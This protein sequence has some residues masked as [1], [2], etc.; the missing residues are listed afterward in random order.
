MFNQNSG[1]PRA[2]LLR[3]PLILAVLAAGLLV[4]GCG[5]SLGKAYKVSDKENVRYAGTATEDEAKR[6]A[7]T[8]REAGY[9]DN[10]QTKDVILR[11]EEGKVATLDFVVGEGWDKAEIIQA[12][13]LMGSEISNRISTKPLTVRLVDPKLKVLKEIPLS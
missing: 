11:K 2:K 1:S 10:S 4:A 9:F 6:I 8:L 13:K 3:F 12:F 7:D 5:P